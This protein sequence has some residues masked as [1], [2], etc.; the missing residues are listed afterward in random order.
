[1]NKNESYSITDMNIIKDNDIYIKLQDNTI[2]SIVLYNNDRPICD[3]V[4]FYKTT[5]ELE[6]DYKILTLYLDIC[7]EYKISNITLNMNN[8]IIYNQVFSFWKFTNYQYG[9]Y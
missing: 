7:V 8:T 3:H 2:G 1:M 5:N 6:V 9:I 4:E